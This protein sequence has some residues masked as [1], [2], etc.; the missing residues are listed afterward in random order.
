MKAFVFTDEA[1][2]G[3]AG[4][5]VWLSIDTEKAQN[6][7]VRKMLKIRALPTFFWIEP[8]SQTVAFRWLGGATVD[9]FSTLLDHGDRAVRTLWAERGNGAGETLE[10]ELARADRLS[11]AGSDSEAVVVYE[12]VLTRAP[13]DWPDYGRALES[14]LFTLYQSGGAEKGAELARASFHRVR[15][16]PSAA[17]TAALG[18][19]MALGLPAEHPKRAEHVAFLEKAVTMVLEDPTLDLGDD[20]RSGVFMSAISAREAAG[21]SVGAHALTERW[22]AFLEQA[23]AKAPTPDA[24]AVFDSHRL[25]AY[26]ELGQPERAIPMLE[27]SERDLPNDY[28]PPARL[29]IIYRNL[30]EYDK[31]L[32]ASDRALA[33]AYGPRR[34]GYLQTRAD[35]LLARGDTPA[36]RKTLEDAV[37]EAEALP[38]GQR[39]DRTIAALK[40]K[41][42]ELPKS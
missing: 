24:R 10:D 11:A 1:L 16:T 7:A 9:H 26:L 13:V 15:G 19:D 8:D 32:S 27:A 25:S 42:E 36:A 35:I 38:D 23:A 17:N 18:L 20:D 34:L 5:F 37:R 14:L 40:K 4:R 30:K 39:S 6:A 33:K 21:D 2:R 28:N 3:Q 22:A 12:D 31:A 41:L 29:A